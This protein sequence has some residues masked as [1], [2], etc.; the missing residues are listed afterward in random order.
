MGVR[1]DPECTY[2]EAN[3]LPTVLYYTFYTSYINLFDLC[4]AMYSRTFDLYHNKER[5]GGNAS[6]TIFPFRN[7]I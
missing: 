4:L 2:P 6:H 5:N 7:E 3:F 1:F